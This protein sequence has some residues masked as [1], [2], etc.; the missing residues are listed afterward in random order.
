MDRARQFLHR[1]RDPLFIL[2]VLLSL[3][4]CASGPEQPRTRLGS[5]PFPGLFTLY[6]TADPNRLGEHRYEAWWDKLDGPGETSRGILYTCRAGFLDLSHIRDSVDWA[7]YIHDR[8]LESLATFGDGPTSS[9]SF[10]FTSS[11]ARYEVELHEPEWWRSLPPTERESLSHEAAIRIGQ[12]VSVVKATWHEIGTWY[13]QETIPGISELNSAFT[14]D[15]S[16]SH[17]VAAIIAGRAL[18][19]SDPW[20][21][22]VT[23]ELNSELARL[24]VVDSSCESTA[25]ARIKDRWWKD[26][27]AVRRDLDTGLATGFKVPWLVPTL[28]Y[29]PNPDPARLP[30]ESLRDVRS[31]D[32][33][34]IV[35]VRITPSRSILRSSLGE[36]DAS[37]AAVQG[38]TDVLR[39][40]DRVQNEME[41]RWGPTATVP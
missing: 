2:V 17:A 12:R 33:S 20:D 25:I 26:G 7:K 29:C 21:V 3:A 19:S 40:I 28:D 4:G 32:L 6:T 9:T 23:R 27:I 41:R 22:A 11:D 8:S 31:R 1:S 5:I 10:S 16:T 30:V 37:P 15:D 38:E 36:P 24:D 39:A 13:G 35:H 14:W 18:R 34:A